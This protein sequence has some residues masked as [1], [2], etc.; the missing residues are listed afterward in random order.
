LYFYIYC[1]SRFEVD[2]SRFFP[3]RVKS[4]FLQVVDLTSF[5][6][7]VWSDYIGTGDSQ[8]H[9]RVIH[10]FFVF[11]VDVYHT[12]KQLHTRYKPTGF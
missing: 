8:V 9:T 3:S 12:K 10:S 7:E 6:V 1:P 11:Q 5:K 4:N 2:L